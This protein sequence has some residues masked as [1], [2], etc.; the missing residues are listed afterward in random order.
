MKIQ[1][2]T[3][4]ATIIFNP[5]GSVKGG[6]AHEHTGYIERRDV[7]DSPKDASGPAGKVD[8]FV[9]VKHDV[10]PIEAK[11]F[12]AFS[13]SRADALAQAAAANARADA[14][15]KALAA[16]RSDH[17][18][19]DK[20]AEAHKAT[21]AEQVGAL[22]DVRAE[23]DQTGKDLT[24]ARQDLKTMAAEMAVQQHV[25]SELTDK[26]ARATAAPAEEKESD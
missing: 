15:D 9:V 23:L 1:A 18:A 21:V 12:E 20:A 24:L 8:V 22:T 6:E 17:A 10:R 3:E 16:A 4:R 25:V 11:D 7:P 2:Y 5:D 19:A 14:A 26:L 13:P